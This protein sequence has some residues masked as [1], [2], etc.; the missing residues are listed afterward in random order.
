MKLSSSWKDTIQGM[1]GRW[2]GDIKTGSHREGQ[3]KWCW[4]QASEYLR[5]TSW[6]GALFKPFR[7]RR[8]KSPFGNLE[9]GS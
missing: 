1:K 2:P 8:L 4:K 6:E 7:R 3:L 9:K 5:K